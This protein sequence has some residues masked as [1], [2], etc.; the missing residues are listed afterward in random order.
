MRRAR[1]RSCSSRALAPHGV[2]VNLI[3]PGT[4]ETDFNRAG[5]ADPAYR[6]AKQALIPAGRFGTPGDVAG[7]ALYLASDGA[8]YVTGATIAVDGGLSL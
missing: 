1:A 5:L 3:A 7:A 6:R 4:I 2:T 8:A